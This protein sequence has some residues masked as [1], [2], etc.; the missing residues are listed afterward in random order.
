MLLLLFVCLLLLLL[1]LLVVVVV[2]VGVGVLD[3]WV[4]VFARTNL[5]S[6]QRRAPDTHPE[7]AAPSQAA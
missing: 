1:L 2:V 6:Y 4:G 7:R 5:A 3:G